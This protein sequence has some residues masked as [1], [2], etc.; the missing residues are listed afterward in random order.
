LWSA[1]DVLI[2]VLILFSAEVQA[3]S[4]TWTRKRDF[5]RARSGAPSSLV[6]GRIHIFGGLLPGYTDAADHAVYDPA[7]DT[8]DTAAPLP[9]PRS[10][11]SSAVVN[12]IIYCIG[13]GFPVTKD[14]V[15]AY[16]P[17]T[18]TWTTKKSLL[19]P[20]LGAQA[21]VVDG[22]IY[23]I[24]G[25]YDQRACEAYDPATD[26]WTRKADRPGC[27]GV[28]SLAVY[29]GIIYTFGGSTYAGG[30][31]KPCASVSA[32]D[33]RANTWTEKTRLPTAR[34]GLQTFL[35]GG[36]IYALG[37]S[38]AEWTALA[39][40]ESYD[41]VSDTWMTESD[42]PK[43]LL[44]YEGAA[45]GTEIHIVGG[46]ADWVVGSTE[47]WEFDPL[48][49]RELL[50]VAPSRYDFQNV[51]CGSSSDTALIRVRNRGS[52]GHQILSV[53]LG[54]SEFRLT[55]APTLPLL[56]PPGGEMQL[57]AV[58][59][60]AVPGMVV[61][62]TLVIETSD[63]LRQRKAVP[64]TGRGAGQVRPARPGVLY[65]VSGGSGD[66][67]S[68]EIEQGSGHAA[69][70]AAVTPHPPPGLST[71]A[72]R[73]RDTTVYGAF[74]SA[75][76]TELFQ[77]SSE[78][79]DLEKFGTIPLGGVSS[80]TF[81]GD[82]RL[83][84]ETSSGRLYRTDPQVLDTVFIGSTGYPFT[85][86]AFSPATGVLWASVHDSLFTV[87]TS[88]GATTMVGCSG[89]DAP[90]SAITFNSLGV[91]YGLYGNWLV[92]IGKTWGDAHEIGMTGVPDLLGIAMRSDV[93]SGLG[94]L[95]IE[96]PL[97]WKLEQNYPNPFNSSTVIRYAVAGE[98]EHRTAGGSENQAG[99][100][101]V[102]LSVYDVLGREVALL[103]DER[104][105]SGEYA[106]TFSS[107]G[108]STG[109]YFCRLV[110]GSIAQTVRMVLI[111]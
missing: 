21:A 81:S 80:I 93:V 29:D 8:W 55:R 16:D 25:N 108:L 76:E 46:T 92:T 102:R 86:L 95:D 59:A 32:F 85:G 79:G 51:L 19:S 12:G 26:T 47:V 58:F 28:L 100:F 1:R 71:L 39:T 90:R 103:V 2:G 36:Q 101:H 72:L 24:G 78:C 42:M 67:R 44:W 61:R 110:A 94:E 106:V 111:R 105:T 13:G 57:G 84:L 73:A 77:L 15:E 96:T 53:S 9:T 41:P 66:V 18:D 82:D 70:S 64:L 48:L 34:F 11:A 63:T 10:F 88:S 45:V 6:N 14:V 20:R 33:P 49:D 104:K 97:T 83:Y 23:N 69:F 37:G 56:L 99:A 40:V 30:I 50:V 87:D 91:L 107:S 4:G 35:V 65:A 7:T 74:S 109:V 3:Q 31:W 75:C 60:P 5:P 68:Y 38:V 17:L 27:G 62:D 54:T 89:W 22:I 52:T 43:R 98:G